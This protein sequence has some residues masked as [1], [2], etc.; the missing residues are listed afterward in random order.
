MSAARPSRRSRSR[1]ARI[2]RTSTSRRLCARLPTCRLA[3]GRRAPIAIQTSIVA[4]LQAWRQAGL[5][6]E[7]TTADRIGLVSAG[8]NTTQNYVY[9]RQAEYMPRPDYLSPR[10]ALQAMDSNQVGVL[11][12]L[13]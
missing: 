13:L 3:W 6:C 5:P 11:S 2:S 1:S 9:G 10:F 7:A 8:H 12:E 4:A